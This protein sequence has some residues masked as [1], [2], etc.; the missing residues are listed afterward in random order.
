MIKF[1]GVFNIVKLI[2]MML[3]HFESAVYTNFIKFGEC[4]GDLL[5][6]KIS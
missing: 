5:A 3:N 1:D 6:F 2:V 4:V